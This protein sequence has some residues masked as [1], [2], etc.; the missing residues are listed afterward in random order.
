MNIKRQTTEC[1]A[2]ARWGVK[3]FCVVIVVVIDLILLAIILSRKRQFQICVLD[4]SFRQIDG[5]VLEMREREG[6]K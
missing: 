6:R 4:R 2:G 1:A 3:P 5:K